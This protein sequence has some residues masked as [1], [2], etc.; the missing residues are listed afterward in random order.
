MTFLN[1][2]LRG[3]AVNLFCFEWNVKAIRLDYIIVLRQKFATSIMQLPG[4]LH[5]A[6]P[7]VEISDRC[8]LVVRNTRG[9]RVENQ[10]HMQ[11]GCGCKN[12]IRNRLT[13]LIPFLEKQSEIGN[14]STVD[15]S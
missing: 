11:G 13:Q 8:S 15:N 2:S 1:R 3:D 9:F 14:N 10:I 5:E 6:R 12:R 4:K 7:V